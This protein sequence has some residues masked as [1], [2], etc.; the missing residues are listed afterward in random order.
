MNCYIYS[1]YVRTQKTLCRYFNYKLM[2]ML[3][4]FKEGKTESY[5][6]IMQSVSE[7]FKAKAHARGA[8]GA[9]GPVW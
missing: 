9:D 3:N 5:S 6:L 2:E 8:L 7:C 4:F 1:Y